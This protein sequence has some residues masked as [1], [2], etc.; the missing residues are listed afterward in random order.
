M[1]SS[2]ADR[3]RAHLRHPCARAFGPTLL[4]LRLAAALGSG[5]AWVPS[6][7]AEAPPAPTE[8]ESV[9]GHDLPSQVGVVR[10]APEEPAEEQE[11]VASA[12]PDSSTSQNS[13]LAERH[14]AHMLESVGGER[15]LEETGFLLHNDNYFAMGAAG[16][17]QKMGKFQ[18]SVRYEVLTLGSTRGYSLSFA[19]TQK[20]FWDV[21]NGGDSRPFVENNYKPEGF[22]SFRPSKHRLSHEYS[23]GVMHESNGLGLLRGRSGDIDQTLQSKSWN[24][25][26]VSV[27]HNLSP[28]LALGR[29]RY[30]FAGSVRAWWPWGVSAGDLPET[31]SQQE[32]KDKKE[33]DKAMRKTL[34][35]VSATLDLRFNTAWIY[36]NGCLANESKGL[37]RV[38]L[39]Q[40]SVETSLYLP[41]PSKGFLKAA[42]YLQY[43]SGRA[44]RLMT[45]DESTRSFYVGIGLL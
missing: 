25:A 37:L 9:T 16:D 23:L 4:S 7:H 6:V 35:Y 20:S 14:T 27:R 42:L 21:L 18:V 30:L 38:T 2:T 13:E 10:A 22:F 44:E 28:Q 36:P 29:F 19:Y 24:H 31:A 1:I 41:V 15:S 11:P 45:Y 26:F 12:P 39:R 33:E 3:T 34:G 32:R 5:L 43:F 17:H 8:L 40:R